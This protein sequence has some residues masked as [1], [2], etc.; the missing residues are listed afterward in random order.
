MDV[1]RYGY[2]QRNLMIATTHTNDIIGLSQVLL[3]DHG[4][5]AVHNLFGLDLVLQD[6]GEDPLTFLADGLGSVR[7][8]MAD[9]AIEAVT[10]YEPY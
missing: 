6:D 7:V 2:D 5:D 10:T 1:L 8:E 4:T 9:E 3:A